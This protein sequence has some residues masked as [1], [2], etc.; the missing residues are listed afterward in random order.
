VEIMNGPYYCARYY[1]PQAGRF[2]NEDP[3]RFKGSGVNFYTYVGDDPLSFADPFGLS[4]CKDCVAY[5][6]REVIAKLEGTA[7]MQWGG[8]GVVSYGTV[9]SA[10]DTYSGL[11]G[12]VSSQK[13]PI[14]L[15]ATVLTSFP[16][17]KVVV[18]I[19]GKKTY[20]TAFGRYQINKIQRLI[21]K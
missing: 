14:I 9:V 17:I 16:N 3:I 2:I 1:E 21:Y 11:V 7:D 12:Q 18:S 5:A 10:S 6:L 15:D 20:S 19:N 8:Y 4:P 13:H